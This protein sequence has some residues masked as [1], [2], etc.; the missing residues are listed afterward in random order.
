MKVKFNKKNPPPPFFLI[1]LS[2]NNYFFFFF[3]IFIDIE[4]QMISSDVGQ[5]TE[6]DVNEASLFKAKIFAMEVG[7]S[8]DAIKLAK[9]DS[10]IINNYKIIYAL[11][12]EIKANLEEY[13]K[14][15][16]N[17]KILKGA[18]KIQNVFQI[19]ISKS[20]IY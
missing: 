5:V 2:N 12:D 9:R 14:V 4:M 8:Q 3:F 11:T 13:S 17:E 15:Q 20:S 18:A 7:S 16:E 1:F 19:K 10:V 6:S